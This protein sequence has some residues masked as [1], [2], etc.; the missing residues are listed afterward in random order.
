MLVHEG[1]PQPAKL[2]GR[3]RQWNGAPEDLQG[4]PGIRGMKAGK[5]L[6]QR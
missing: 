1:K 3:Q 6:D 5:N 2:A 4:C